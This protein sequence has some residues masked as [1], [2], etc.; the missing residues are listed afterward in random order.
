MTLAP[1]P[2]TGDPDGIA[3]WAQRYKQTAQS[4]QTAAQELRDL[5][6]DD[7]FVS[8]AVDEIRSKAVETRDSTLAIHTRIDGAADAFAVYASELSAAQARANRAIA[9]FHNASGPSTAAQRKKDDLEHQVK[10]DQG[11]TP[12]LLEQFKEA[13]RDVENYAAHTGAAL[14]EYERAVQDKRDAVTRASHALHDAGDKSGLNDNFFE[15]IAGEF[16]QAYEWAQKYLA[17]VLEQLHEILKQLSDILSVISL[18]VTVLAVFIPVLAPLAAA[19]NIV[20]LAVA[21]LMLLC[22]LTLFLLGKGSLGAVLGDAISVV[23][24]KF[25]GKL[26]GGLA[27]G[28]A[29]KAGAEAGPFVTSSANT[30]L[31]P[32]G[33]SQVAFLLEHGPTAGQMIEAGSEVVVDKTLEGVSSGVSDSVGGVLGFEGW[34]LAPN[35]AGPSWNAPP[36]IHVPPVFGGH[37]GGVQL[38]SSTVSSGAGSGMSIGACA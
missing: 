32:T 16:Q 30:L 23:A 25:G 7:T 5:T 12:D 28:I 9:A 37:D 18:I 10:A 8:L 21:G 19:L 14:V 24:A 22:S 33:A 26:A 20:T 34:D 27:E 15:A 1:T 4:L 35:A 11:Q 17:P 29:A 31:N 6:N 36:A 38:V 13:V 2:L 3:R